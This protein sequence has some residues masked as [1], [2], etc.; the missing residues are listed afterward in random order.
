MDSKLPLVAILRGIRPEELEL[1][2]PALIDAGFEAVEIPLNSEH[3]EAGIQLA[4]QRYAGQTRI[5]AGTVLRP[6]QVRRLSEL[7]CQLIVTP[8]V[9]AE[10]IR[11]GLAAGMQLLPG[12][13]TATEAF[14]AI[15]A[16]ARR[17]KLFPAGALGPAYLAALRT[18]LPE[19]VEMYAV[20]GVKP[21]TLA[22]YLRAGCRGAGLGG[23]LYRAGQAPE[24]TR[25]QA[26]AF[27]RAYREAVPRQGD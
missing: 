21:E 13:A 2:V 8:N 7:G 22:D 15:A 4:A 6:E 19:S 5:G 14:D 9:N 23:E 24:R 12:C 17:I 3:W 20:G 27:A 18:V 10:V 25:A 16:G 26:Q 11:L 1:H